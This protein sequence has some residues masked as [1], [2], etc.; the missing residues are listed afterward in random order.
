MLTLNE[1]LSPN[2]YPGRGVM[3]GRSDDGKCAVAVY[4]IMGR[5]RN[6]RNRVFKKEGDDLVIR[7]FDPSL[8]E[9]PSLIIYYPVRTLGNITLVTNGDQTDTAAEFMRAGKT[10]EEALMTRTF[11][12]DAPNFTPRISGMTERKGGG[13]TYTL[14]IL[15]ATDILGKT[16]GRFFFSYESAPGEGRI[17]HT[18]IGDGAP[19]PPFEGEPR[20]V[21]LTG[22]IN[23]LTSSVWN[24]LDRDNRVSLY[25]RFTDIATGEYDERIVNAHEGGLK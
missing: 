21:A 13:L 11:E 9:D 1:Y 20:R 19:L 2:R 22:G 12:P 14:S 4:F 6:S 18:Y 25:V 8:V 10:F 7:P 24:A 5:S 23:A 17:I 15:K 3:I 16:S